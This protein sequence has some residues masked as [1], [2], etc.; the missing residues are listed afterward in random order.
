LLVLAGLTTSFGLMSLRER[1]R[2][3]RA[4]NDA[5]ADPLTGLS[6]R[7]GFESQLG[8]EWKRAERYSHPLGLLLL[9]LDGFKQVNDTHGHATG[10][11][12]L[13]EAAAVIVGRVRETDVAARL[14]GDEF[15]VI[16]PETHGPGLEALADG[17]RDELAEH[18]IAAS[19]GF[20]QR[21]DADAGPS[22]LI[23]RA[24]EAMYRQKADHRQTQASSSLASV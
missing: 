23:A 2:S 5:L 13:R 22:E 4:A 16:C 14:G 6:N 8:K 19:V 15:V 24:D 17:L 20:A 3:V 7:H 10:D 21:E 11:R 1:R 12:V 18:S 9:D